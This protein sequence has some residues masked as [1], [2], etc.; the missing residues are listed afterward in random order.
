MIIRVLPVAC[1][2]VALLGCSNGENGNGSGGSGGAG[3]GGTGGGGTNK[4][5]SLLG[6]V[7]GGDPST[8]YFDSSSRLTAPTTP[9]RRPTLAGSAELHGTFHAQGTIE[10]SDPLFVRVGNLTCLRPPSASYTYNVDVYSLTLVG[11]GPHNL[12]V[13]TCA[14]STDTFL[15]LYQ[16]SEGSAAPFDLDDACP[17]MVAMDDDGCRVFGP[18]RIRANGLRAGTVQIAVTTSGTSSSTPIPYDLKVM[19]DTSCP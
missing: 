12:I 6:Q 16:D 11:A 14:S 19:S 3:A 13:D 1:I 4:C 17:H 18:A 15:L 9:A 8:F 5:P 2:A 10:Q 7:D